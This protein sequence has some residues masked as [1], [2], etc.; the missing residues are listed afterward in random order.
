M[1]NYNPSQILIR[2][3]L[4]EYKARR[5]LLQKKL[6]TPPEQRTDRDDELNPMPYDLDTSRT[7][8]R[9]KHESLIKMSTKEFNDEVRTTLESKL[10]YVPE[11]GFHRYEFF[12]L[13]DDNFQL[14][15]KRKPAKGIEFV[16][17]KYHKGMIVSADHL[18]HVMQSDT[19]Y[20]F[21][22]EIQFNLE[23][24]TFQPIHWKM[25]NL[26]Q[27]KYPE[28]LRYT[29]E[30]VRPLGTTDATFSNFN[31]A[32]KHTDD[33][34]EPTSNRILRHILRLLDTQPYPPVHFV[35]TQALHFPLTTGTGYYNR[36]S[37][38]RDVYAHHAHE[39][40]YEGMY[41]KKGYYYNATY[42]YARTEIH[43]IKENGSPTPISPNSESSDDEIEDYIRAT[44][45][46]YAERPTILFTRNHISQPD[47]LK[48]RPVCATD[49]SMYIAD[50]MIFG[51][52][53]LQLRKPSCCVMHG[54]E[55]LRGA[56]HFL[57]WTAKF[58]DSYGTFDWKHLDQSNPA[59]IH[60][61][62]YLKWL[63]EVLII[64]K[65]YQPTYEYPEYPDLTPDLMYKRLDNLINFNMNW[66]LNMTF[67]TAEGYA[68]RREHGGECSGRLPTQLFQS[69]TTI[70]MIVH[71]L[72]EFG[73]T[74]DE[75]IDIL[76]FIMGD[77]TTI[78]THWTLQRLYDFTAFFGTF[79]E[80]RWNMI[81]SPEKSVI[82]ELRSKIETLQY[83]CN[84]GMPKRP[85]G[86]LVGQIIYPEHGFQEKYMSM[87]SIGIHLASCGEDETLSELL[88]DIYNLYLP[89]AD[90]SKEAWI[91][92]FSWLQG[93]VP[94]DEVEIPLSLYMQEFPSIDKVRRLISTYHGPLKYQPKWNLKY[95][96]H[97]P[98][99][100]YQDYETMASYRR[101]H[102]IVPRQPI[103]FPTLMI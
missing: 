15:E 35:D 75:I 3:Y 21:P 54:L 70:F 56:N 71:A 52:A 102:G 37:A 22:Q 93:S 72:I 57:D 99:H 14:P 73:C 10:Q 101:K 17:L 7:L 26:I 27:R 1:S 82:T 92:T 76:M 86:K 98:D 25:M 44:V 51:P 90:L 87:R 29:V 47:R 40:E 94:R 96:K 55:T 23:G 50:T 89:N 12:R 100:I 61:H 78:F 69:Y 43:Y 88:H 2:N 85:I 74:D 97:Q 42:H 36:H 31:H 48:S 46:Y 95:F 81:I 58:Y 68:Y 33:L 24:N 32:M 19:N 103:R 63:P 84:F 59:Y 67:L 66:N 39:P 80:R 79:A 91:K 62:F 65:G 64:N 13:Y 49:D 20:I 4:A 6:P 34:D 53:L 83:Q 16:P 8:G 77:D 11:K 5:H 9:Q 38:R 30:Y 41:T 45:K 60:K 28:Y 18:L